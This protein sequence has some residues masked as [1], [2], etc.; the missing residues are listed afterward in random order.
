[1]MKSCYKLNKTIAVVVNIR[2]S[3]TF[4][5]QINL[6][7]NTTKELERR[8]SK[9]NFSSRNEVDNP[10]DIAIVKNS[11]RLGIKRK[12][13]YI[14]SNQLTFRNINT[15]EALHQV[16]GQLKKG[17]LPFATSQRKENPYTCRCTEKC[18]NKSVDECNSL[19]N[20]KAGNISAIHKKRM[21][22]VIPPPKSTRSTKDLLK[23]K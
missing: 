18:F 1:M 11:T 7:P 9:I 17:Y 13:T 6:F 12:E 14:S 23:L 4:V 16:E 21:L 2:Y 15:L 19:S 10:I 5:K 20:F 22:A 3:I 8:E